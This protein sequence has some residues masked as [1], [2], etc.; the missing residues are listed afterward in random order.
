MHA[1]QMCLHVVGIVLVDALLIYPD[2][3]GPDT[4]V[5]AFCILNNAMKD[6]WWASEAPGGLLQV[7]AIPYTVFREFYSV[8]RL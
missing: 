5:I 8:K 7:G 1:L 4:P 6:D 2:R 3:L